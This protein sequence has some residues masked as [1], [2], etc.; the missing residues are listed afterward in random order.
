MKMEDNKR[1]NKLWLKFKIVSN[2]GE[3]MYH[4]MK[5]SASLYRNIVRS[6]KIESLTTSVNNEIEKKIYSEL[7]AYTAILTQISL[8]DNSFNLIKE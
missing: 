5:I 6:A 4:E 7:L 8:R 1:Q 2:N 3:V